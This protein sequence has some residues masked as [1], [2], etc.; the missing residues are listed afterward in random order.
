MNCSKP[1][2]RYGLSIMAVM[3]GNQGTLRYWD[4]ATTISTHK[5]VDFV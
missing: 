4:S 3:T 1:V 5:S 2:Y